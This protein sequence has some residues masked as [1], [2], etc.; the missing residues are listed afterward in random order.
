MKLQKIIG[1]LCVLPLVVLLSYVFLIVIWYGIL[2]IMYDSLVNARLVD[3]VSLLIL[4]FAI[5]GG[6]LLTPDVNDNEVE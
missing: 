1:V 6:V 2:P 4:I 5:I 3:W